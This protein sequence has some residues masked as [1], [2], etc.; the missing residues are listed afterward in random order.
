M[1]AIPIKD[2]SA[3]ASS[4]LGKL[5]TASTFLGSADRPCSE[6][7]NPKNSIS[8][9]ENLHLSRLIVSPLSFSRCNTLFR[10][11]SCYLLI[12]AIDYYVITNISYTINIIY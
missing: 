12:F 3:F 6:N 4:G 1:F 11:K 8:D 10:D 5:F 2:R 9:T 7:L